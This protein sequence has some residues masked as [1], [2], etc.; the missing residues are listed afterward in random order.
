MQTLSSTIAD[1]QRSERN[2][3]EAYYTLQGLASAHELAKKD[4]FQIPLAQYVEAIAAAMAFLQSL[5]VASSE[6]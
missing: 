6:Q 2:V 1:L 3:Q 5:V 4:G